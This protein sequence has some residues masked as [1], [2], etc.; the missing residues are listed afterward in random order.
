MAD[1]GMVGAG[2]IQLT[3]QDDCGALSLVRAANHLSVNWVVRGWRVSL[4]HP[5]GV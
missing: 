2:A 5:A 3:I 1:K 4:G